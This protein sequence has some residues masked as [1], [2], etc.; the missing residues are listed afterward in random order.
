MDVI[1]KLAKEHK[2]KQ[3][4]EYYETLSPQDRREVFKSLNRSDLDMKIRKALIGNLIT[5]YKK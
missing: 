5:S 2:W 3:L 1:K 4:K